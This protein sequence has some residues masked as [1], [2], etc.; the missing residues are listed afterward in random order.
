M[1]RSSI[2]SSCD[3]SCQLPLVVRTRIVLVPLCTSNAFA[4]LPKEKISTVFTH[5]HL[6]ANDL[7]PL[8]NVDRVRRDLVALEPLQRLR[9]VQ[10]PQWFSIDV[11][12]AARW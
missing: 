11:G 5:R 2:S 4:T 3:I 10:L 6:V 1:P 9:Q 7:L 12:A 8:D